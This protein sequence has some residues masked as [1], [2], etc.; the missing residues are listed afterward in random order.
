MVLV[1]LGLYTGYV[2]YNSIFFE[3]MI[4]VFRVS[5]NVGFL[6]YISDAFG[7]LG[8]VAVM[9][10]KEVFQ[11]KVKW[12]YLYPN[13]VV[14]FSVVGIVATIASL[15]YFNKKYKLS[16]GKRENP[17]LKTHTAQGVVGVEG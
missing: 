14:I 6:I 16:T 2:P 1:G 10:S 9:L 13:A 3:R 8:S 4:A 17:P 7:Y 15:A 12:S 5:G 11:V